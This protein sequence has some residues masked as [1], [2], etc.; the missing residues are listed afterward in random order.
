MGEWTLTDDQHIEKEFAYYRDIRKTIINN[1]EKIYDV[2]RNIMNE[3][4]IRNFDFK[5]VEKTKLLS[6]KLVFIFNSKTF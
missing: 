2:D 6:D 1:W 4:D 5:K 3:D